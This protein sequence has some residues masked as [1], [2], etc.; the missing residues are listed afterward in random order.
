MTTATKAFE[1]IGMR[2]YSPEGP[3]TS[4]FANQ[5]AIPSPTF[6][7][8]T[9]IDGDFEAEF[10][11]VWFAPVAAVTLNQGDFL[12]WD[13]SYIARQLTTG[14][15]SAAF[16]ESVGVFFL[17][18]R[19]G[20][21]AAAPNAGNVWSYTFQPGLYLIWLQRAGT[22]VLNIAAGGTQT[23]PANSTAVLGQ[24]SQPASP[25]A[26]S[27]GIQNVFAAPTVF[28]FTGNATAGSAII[29]AVSTNRGLV[30]GQIATGTG[31][32]AN[33]YVQDIS[34][35]T[36]TLSNAATA[37]NA[38]ITVTATAGATFGNVTINSNVITGVPVIEGVYPNQTI[39][40]T[41]I[42]GSTVI[43][44]ISGVPGNY[45]INI[46]AN[47][48]ATN[49]GVALTTSG[50]QEGFLRWPQVASQN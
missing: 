48:T 35:T 21:P 24:L 13:N 50:Y 38:G 37:T 18:G 16:G 9:C 1:A 27:M 34:G 14:A 10:T 42:P 22:Q 6:T 40:G 19:V 7:P 36:V 44:S 49:A 11:A 20:D 45:T 29:T 4:L 46:S 8:G 47:A 5:G 25:L 30:R 3:F 23:K 26:G 33:T 2:V 15:G 17:G 32:P 28:T 41:G 12:S 31:I 43:T 39:A